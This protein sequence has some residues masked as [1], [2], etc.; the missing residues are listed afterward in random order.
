MHIG[1][2][3]KEL[4][5]LKLWTQAQLA[6]IAGVSERTVRRLE[7]TGKAENATLLSILEALDTNPKELE[8]MF[9][10]DDTIKEESKEKFADIGF[11][12]RIESGRE[13]VRIISSAHQYGYDYH[14]CKT[15]EQIENAQVF[16]S[17]VADLLDIWDMI[18]IGQRF[19]YENDLTKQIKELEELGL[20]VFG[21][22]QVNEKNNWVTAIIEI[23]SK[24]NPMIQKVKLDKDMVQKN[25]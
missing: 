13:L 7:A 23:Y 17:V 16:L 15:E 5:N 12:H 9:N 21:D 8:N 6:E 25:K 10:E 18:E 2:K 14:D 3:I 24:D 22:R 11:L 20:W 4:R 19:N 1:L